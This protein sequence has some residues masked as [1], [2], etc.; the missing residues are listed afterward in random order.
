MVKVVSWDHDQ[1]PE[2]MMMMMT[3]NDKSPVCRAFPK[4]ATPVKKFPVLNN[5]IGKRL[6]KSQFSIQSTIT[7]LLSV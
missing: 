7:L 6:S 3:V 2:M 5:N 1:V 4:A